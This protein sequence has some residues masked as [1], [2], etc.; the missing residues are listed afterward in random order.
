M[1]K[2]SVLLVLLPLTFFACQSTSSNDDDEVGNNSSEEEIFSSDERASS[3]EESSSSEEERIQ[4]QFKKAPASQ[5]PRVET[6][7]LTWDVSNWDDDFEIKLT[8]ELWDGN[9]SVLLEGENREDYLWSTSDVENGSHVRLIVEVSNDKGDTDKDSTE[10]FDIHD[11]ITEY[12]YEDDIKDLLMIH[13]ALCHMNGAERGGVKLDAYEYIRNTEGLG[14]SILNRV[15]VLKD[16]PKDIGQD[17]PSDVERRKVRDWI[18]GGMPEKNNDPSSSSEDISLESSSSEEGGSSEDQ[19]SSEQLSSSEVVSSVEESS[20][21]DATSSEEQSSSSES[22]SSDILSSSESS[23]SESSSSLLSSSSESSSSIL[24]SSS[25]FSSSESSSSSVS[26]SSESSSSSVS[27]SSESSSSSISSDILVGFTSL[28]GSPVSPDNSAMI[29]W[30]VSEWG[31]DFTY[32]LS[33]ETWGGAV[34]EIGNGTNDK[35]HNWNTSELNNGE[36]I[37]L[38]IRVENELG[39]AWQETSSYIDIHNGITELTYDEDIYPLLYQ[40]CSSCHMNGHERNGV[41]FDTYNDIVSGNDV[42]NRMMKQVFIDET[43]PDDPSNL[44]SDEERMKIRNWILGGFP[45]N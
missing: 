11:G 4:V 20:S 39:G 6:E 38:I 1:K 2:L 42:P 31:G 44:P 37:K 15:T 5:T 29:E 3:E 19:S 13:C 34:I 28:P 12:N 24:S 26:S 7:R 40:Y 32:T 22:S 30:D 25:M 27:S 17:L 23:S 41:K 43:M 35:E 14:Q 45:E 18:L 36:R 16:M 8:L 33:Y 21:S 9:S 10:Y